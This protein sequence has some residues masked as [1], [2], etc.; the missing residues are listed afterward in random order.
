M[1]VGG[2]NG[3]INHVK[4]EYPKLMDI[5]RLSPIAIELYDKGGQLKDANQACLDLFG[6]K[7]VKSVQ[8][9]N[10]FADPNI[11]EQAITDVKAGNA[12][13]YEFLFDFDLVK[14]NKLYE[15]TKDGTCFLEC[16]I[17]PITNNSHEVTGYI[18][19]ITDITKRK[20]IEDSL[21]RSEE[22]YRMLI[23]LAPDA[24]YQGNSIGNLITVNNSATELT[25]YSREELLRMNLKNLFSKD[26]LSQ[27]PLRYDLLEQ[28]EVIK[29][30]RVIISKTGSPI[31]VEMNSKK[32]P[33]GTYQ[34]FFR[35]ITERKQAEEALQKSEEKF[36]RIVESSTSGM[37]FYQ[38]DENDQLIVIGANP[39]ADHILGFSHQLFLGKTI[40]EILP[41]LATTKFPALGKSIAKGEI[42][43]QI[44]DIEYKDELISGFFSIQVFQTEK[45]TIT[46][47]FTE[48]TERKNAEK[49]LETQAKE[50]QELNATKDK[51][52]SIIAHDLKNPFNAIIGF[53]NL[54][55]QNFNELD[56]ETFH[57]GLKTIESASNRAYKLLE[58]LLL[59][60]QNQTGRIQFNPEKFN[61]TKHIKES[62]SMV[63]SA[64]INKEIRIV[65]DIKKAYPVFADKNMID[66]ILRNLISN[67]IKFSHKGGK[68]NLKVTKLDHE[69]HVSVS[70]NGVGISPERQTAIFEIDKRSNTLGTDNEQGT[71]LGLLLCKDFVNWHGGR[72]WVE[73]TPGKGSTF[74][75][76]LSLN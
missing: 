1:K 39:A 49:L 12:I 32:M 11:P 20:Q 16:Y 14:S 70:D 5:F 47:D 50:L 51:F 67:A 34:S 2:E 72:I 26:Y 18:V 28:G 3:G 7:N 52:L 62:L 24:F 27:K 43:S 38:L 56:D 21:R 54:M 42:G 35:N 57:K 75:F 15:T 64:A 23:N 8:G 76:S 17:T 48:I 60:S 33:D 65:T 58:N 22:Q 59:W 19:H 40:E 30:E 36:R 9:F 29:T 44:F 45:D 74:T 63:E 46:V 25:G 37:Y 4:E 6:I 73:S 10:L 69:L 41:K 13:R 61:L 53:S 68:I 71:G 55:L 31:S 66:L